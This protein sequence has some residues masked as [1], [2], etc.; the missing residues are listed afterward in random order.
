MEHYRLLSVLQQHGKTSAMASGKVKGD[1][2]WPNHPEYDLPRPRPL[3][4]PWPPR[5][6][7]LA[8]NNDSKTLQLT[9]KFAFN[10]ALDW[11]YDN[12][13][14]PPWVSTISLWGDPFAIIDPAQPPPQ[15][16]ITECGTLTSL[17]IPSN[18]PEGPR[19]NLSLITQNTSIPTSTRKRQR[20]S[21][22]VNSEAAHKRQKPSQSS[23]LVRDAPINPS[24][25]P[26][27]ENS[28]ALTLDSS[29]DSTSEDC[30]TRFPCPFY[31][32]DPEKYSAGRY[33]RCARY[34]W[35]IHRLKQHISRR[36]YSARCD[37]CYASFDNL[38]GLY[39]H[40]QV[41]NPCKQQTRL[42]SD[43]EHVDERIDELQMSQI[44][45]RM[46]GKPDLE[47]WK[48]IY[49]IAFRLDSSAI[50]P[51]P[52][53]RDRLAGSVDAFSKDFGAFLHEKIGAS[54][55]E[56]TKWVLQGSLRLLEHYRRSREVAST[57]HKPF[58]M[59]DPSDCANTSDD[60]VGFCMQPR[61][62]QRNVT[63][64]EGQ[65]YPLDDVEAILCCLPEIGPN[66]ET[67]DERLV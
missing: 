45:D 61:I 34:E 51:S 67:C 18:G 31:L 28:L 38:A 53:R 55:D 50:V 41:P 43:F 32:H 49:R 7:T 40:L 21:Q 11:S 19:S 12:T 56:K 3:K 44:R 6:S 16:G 65:N 36:H 17:E 33:H 8:N 63:V 25:D 59:S 54:T 58:P 23:I 26:N 27:K 1:R 14:A 46:R 13:V 47:K 48:A 22:I 35:D 15:P 42:H 24:N 37:R 62:H 30:K 57:R 20:P 2:R 60:S 66:L 52:C 4:P 10:M 64:S 39:K 9:F 29:G 5:L